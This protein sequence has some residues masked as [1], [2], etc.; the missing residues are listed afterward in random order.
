[1][2]H[3]RD[4]Y[5]SDLGGQCHLVVIFVWSNNELESPKP[6]RWQPKSATHS[7]AIWVTEKP[8][9]A[10]EE[11]VVNLLWRVSEAP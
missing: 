7:W 3:V 10:W 8:K 9:L 1:M 4:H 5:L 11:K 6:F 2:C